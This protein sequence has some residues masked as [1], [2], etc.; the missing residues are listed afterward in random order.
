MILSDGGIRSYL[1]RG[2]LKVNPLNENQIRENGIDLTIGFQ[3]ARFKRTSEVLDVTKEVDLSKYYNI[4]Y[5]DEEGIVIEPY[6]HV[7]LHTTEY[8]EMPPD[9]VGLVNLKSSFARLGL[10]IPPTV[11]DAGFKGEIVIEVIGSSFPVRVRPG[12][13]FIHLIFLRTDSPVVR[14]YSVSGHYQGQRGVRLPR[15]PIKL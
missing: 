2:L 5:M 9:L 6:E 3:Y 12:V 7:L 15:L 4:G 14:D 1:S 13:P 10:Y 11:V 8:I